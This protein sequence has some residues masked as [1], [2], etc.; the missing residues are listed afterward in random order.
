MKEKSILYKIMFL[1]EC[2]MKIFFK[3]A[4]FLF[5]FFYSFKSVYLDRAILIDYVKFENKIPNSH[6]GYLDITEVERRY[7]RSM[8]SLNVDKEV[9]NNASIRDNVFF[10]E[11]ECD[12]YLFQKDNLKLLDIGCGSGV[13]SKIFGREG[14]KTAKWEYAGT[15][16]DEKLIEVCKKYSPKEIFF[17]STSD[18]LGASNDS[19]DLIFSSGVMHYTLDSW[20]E[21]ILEMKRVSKRYIV[22]TRFPLAKF[23]DTFYVK[24]TVKSFSGTEVHY[25]ICINRN[26]FEKFLKE[27]GLKIIKRDYS[28]EEYNVKGIHEKIVLAQYLLEK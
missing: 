8:E 6:V 12:E 9:K 26:E 7:D 18:K 15:E 22:I 16:I 25:F 17:A 14:S 23:T 11:K 24:Q 10:L 28:L 3:M 20:R 19:F 1:S 4:H 2:G 21:S 13:Y 5:D 27:N